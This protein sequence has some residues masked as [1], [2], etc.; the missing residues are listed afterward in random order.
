M[1][2]PAFWFTNVPINRLLFTYDN[3]KARVWLLINRYLVQ[4]IM[5]LS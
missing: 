3:H 4:P 1:L 5:G 2:R